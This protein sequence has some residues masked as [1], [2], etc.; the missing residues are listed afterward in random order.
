MYYQKTGSE[1]VSKYFPIYVKGNVMLLGAGFVRMWTTAVS[2]R[3]PCPMRKAVHWRRVKDHYLSGKILLVVVTKDF[4]DSEWYKD[5]VTRVPY[6]LQSEDMVE[7]LDAWNFMV[8]TCAFH[9][10]VWKLCFRIR[11]WRKRRKGIWTSKIPYA[12]LVKMGASLT[13]ENATCFIE[14]AHNSQFC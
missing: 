2:S 6:S 13:T 14:C 1:G 7:W 10:V 3:V 4:V 11:T 12:S 9:Y 8:K 5:N